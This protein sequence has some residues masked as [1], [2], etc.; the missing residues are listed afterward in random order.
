MQSLKK[1][2]QSSIKLSSFVLLISTI[3]FLFFH[4]PFYKFV[5]NNINYKT[6]NGVILI[7][8]LVLIM[9]VFNAFFFFLILFLSRVV[10]KFLLVV[11]FI[12][13]AFAVY[14]INTYG[15]IIDESMIGN[16]L[17][18]SFKESSSFFSIKLLLYLF[19]L[20]I[21]PS[22]YIIKA[23]IE[24]I[25]LKKY[26]LTA[27][28]TLLFIALVVFG[29]SSNFL[30]I[31]KN[32]KQLGGL[33]MPWCYAVNIGL[34]YKHKNEK[35]KTEILLPNATIMDNKK[36][37]MVL[38]IGESARSQ[39]FSLY[40]YNKNTNPLLSNIKTYFILMLPLVLLIQQ[41]VLSVC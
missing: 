19:L 18:T 17:N 27:L 29:N 22:L 20:G 14:F 11:S 31:D 34:F 10:G 41:L 23:K 28:T 33:A 35:N 16:V 4:Y 39:N 26:L 6:V 12:I 36:S 7:A 40:G 3:N 5:F 37:V 13:N 38:V 1:W 2:L 15:V 30:W 9:I 25:T 21:V 32:S 8:S 24:K